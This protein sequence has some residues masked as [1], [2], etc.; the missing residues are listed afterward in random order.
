MVYPNPGRDIFQVRTAG[1]EGSLLR[2]TDLLGREILRTE[3]Q[4][5]ETQVELSSMPSGTYFFRIEGNN[6]NK[7]VKVVK[8]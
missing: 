1:L 3:I 2:V 4:M 5:N 8:R 7:V 6:F